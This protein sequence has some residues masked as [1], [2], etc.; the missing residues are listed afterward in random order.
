MIGSA[1][2]PVRYTVFSDEMQDAIREFTADGGHILVSGAN[3]A[4]D[5]W[6][7]VYQYEKD[8]DFQKESI[9]FAENVLGYKLASSHACN[10][11]EVYFTNCGM[12]ETQKGERATFYNQVN[13]VCYS[14]ESPDGIYPKGNAATFMRYADTDISAAIC[15]DGTQYKSVCIGFPLETL[16]EE[17]QIDNIISLT[18]DYFKK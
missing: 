17:S 12:F 6:S 3:I 16:R 5:I 11:G 4:T 8:E 15:K 2:N 1:T 18:L 10:T 13:E 9:Q 14:V 7:G